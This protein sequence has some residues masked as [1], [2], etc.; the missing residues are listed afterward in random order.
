MFK[1]AAEVCAGEKWI[2]VRLR[3]GRKELRER[4]EGD[5]GVSGRAEGGKGRKGNV[6]EDTAVNGLE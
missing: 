1:G 4:E 5:C 6:N 3:E 2:G